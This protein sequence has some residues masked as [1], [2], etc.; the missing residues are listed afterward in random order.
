MPTRDD[1]V[2]EP[3][4]TEDTTSCLQDVEYEKREL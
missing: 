4:D 1:P 3:L 2:V